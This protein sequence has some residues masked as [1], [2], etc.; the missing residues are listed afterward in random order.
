MKPT[1]LR[2]F[3]RI[4]KAL[5]IIV[6]SLIII[7]ATGVTLFINLYPKEDLLDIITTGSESALHRKISIGDI[8]YSV[9]GIVLNKVII[10]DGPTAK[11]PIFAKSEEVNLQFSIFELI[12]QRKLTFDRIGLLNLSLNIIYDKDGKSNIGNFL[13]SIKT[14]KSTES[15]VTT[16]ISSIYLQKA[17][18][19]L[20]NPPEI[21]KPLEGRYIFTGTLSLNKNKRI[22]ISNCSIVLPGKRGR[23]QPT[24]SIYPEK[25][26]KITGGTLLK[27]VSLSWV[28][29]WSKSKNKMPW[30]IVNGRVSK[31]QITRNFVKGH[32]KVTSSLTNYNKIVNANGSCHVNIR[33]R[34]I[35]LDNIQ[36]SI[37]ETSFSLNSL[38][39]GFKGKL[40]KFKVTNINANVKDVLPILSFLPSQLSGKVAG[41]LYYQK[42]AFN[43]TLSLK[44]VALDAKNS[45]LTNVSTNITIKNNIF[46]KQ[47]IPVFV[48]KNPCLVSI[49]STDPKL[50]KLFINLHSKKLV[51][52]GLKLSGGK[53]NKEFKSKVEITGSVN[54]RELIYNK[55]KFSKFQAHYALRGA[56]FNI[57]GFSSQFLDGT[58]QGKGAIN[59]SRKPPQASIKFQFNNIKVQNIAG[60]TKKFKDRFFGSSYGT[61]ALDFDIGENLEKSLYGKVEF[62]IRKGKLVNTG[63]QNGLGIFLSEL[64][65]KLRDLEFKRIYGNLTLKG[66]NYVVNSFIFNSQNIR[67]K[68]EGSLNKEFVARPLLINL[69]FNRRF[70]EDVPGP[71]AL[72]LSKYNT[73]NWYVIPFSCVGDITNSK[74]IKRM[75]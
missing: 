18:I 20:K 2:T 70:I 23:V 24:V 73:G 11:D 68:I 33:G 60:F 43:G 64:K 74:N 25:N 54:I 52:N 29:R 12:F 34:K 8:N 22:D 67:L 49:A 55:L 66:K 26:F 28:Y 32:A 37:G 71:V 65:Y 1:K 14:E 10:H 16:D 31:L 48:N 35:N 41:N 46:K 50:K 21:L 36:G 53:S 51:L 9:R 15:P 58:L 6:I 69:E 45:L 7:V 3:K 39:L 13:R 4:V 61:V 38:I 47:N 17:R 75:Q 56:S 62:N 57:N 44:N 30:D 5:L 72:I 40:I 59:I 27:N 63:V 19:T 42:E